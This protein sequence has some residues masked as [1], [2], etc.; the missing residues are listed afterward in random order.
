MINS[1]NKFFEECSQEMSH[2]KTD[3]NKR[4]IKK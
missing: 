4:A 2:K 3:R 1:K